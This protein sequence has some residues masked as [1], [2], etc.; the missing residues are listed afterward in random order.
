MRYRWPSLLVVLGIMA[1]LSGAG[2]HGAADV[3]KPGSASAAD[4]LA[5]VRPAAD[6]WPW[7]CGPHRNN[8]A[9]E[10]QNAPVRWSETE[11]VVWRADVPGR[12]HGSPCLWGDRIFLPTADDEAEVQYL[13]C[14]ERAGGHKLWQTEVHRGGFMRSHRKGSHASS[15]PACDGHH[16]FVPFMVQGGVW[17]TALGFDGKI[18]WQKRLGDF[19]S[20]HGFAASPVVYKSM[21]IVVADNVRGSF[22][23]AVHRR[24]GEVVWKTERPDYKLGSFANPAVGYVAGR[25]QLLL[26]GPHKVFS[27]DPATGDLL[28]TCDGPSEST[29][30]TMS[31]GCRLVYCSGGYP[32]RSLLAI[33]ADGGGDV[34]DTHVVWMKKDN[35]AYVPSML[36]ADGLLYMVEDEGEATC[37][38][39]ATGAVVWQ[40][41]LDGDFSSSPVLAGGHVYVVNEA[42]VAYVFKSGR[43]FELVARN[44]LADGGFATPVVCGGRIYLRSLHHLYCLGKQP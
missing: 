44:D 23:A 21:A 5:P 15:T 3:P 24:T 10:P 42:G 25:D 12:G 19:K 27:Y 41:E 18:A 37:F 13:L 36:L 8:V 2:S 17:L 35:T 33:R 16:V 30:N 40:A 38:E 39:A 7:W 28:W 31:L 14:Y 26:H 43:K 29:S 22:M 20:M 6:D 34:T 11:N 9:A 1:A 32:E 4:E